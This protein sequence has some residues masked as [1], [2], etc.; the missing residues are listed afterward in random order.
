[1]TKEQEKL[2]NDLHDNCRHC[3]G[4]GEEQ[5]FSERKWKFQCLECNGTGKELSDFGW[6]LMNFVQENIKIKVTA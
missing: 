2:I 3:K 6:A 5:D 4:T 1:M